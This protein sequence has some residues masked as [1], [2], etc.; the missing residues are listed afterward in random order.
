MKDMKKFIWH[1]YVATTT[2]TTQ[3]L[4]S[5]SAPTSNKKKNIFFFLIISF[6]RQAIKK[7]PMKSITRSN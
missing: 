5:I 3:V 6:P 1:N 7:L 2:T 4:G